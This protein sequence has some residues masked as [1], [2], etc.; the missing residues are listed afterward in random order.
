VNVGDMSREC[1]MY[2]REQL[3][4]MRFDRKALMKEIII[5]LDVCRR[6]ILK[7]RKNEMVWIGLNWLK[8]EASARLS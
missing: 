8:I 3:W 6:I 4:R 5:D 7:W 2:G 1:S